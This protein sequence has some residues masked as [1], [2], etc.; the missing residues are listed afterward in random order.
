MLVAMTSNPFGVNMMNAAFS[1]EEYQKILLKNSKENEGKTQ[2]P[3]N[4]K[5][6]SKNGKEETKEPGA[7]ENVEGIAQETEEQ[8]RKNRILEKIGWIEALPHDLLENRDLIPLIGGKALEGLYGCAE[9][10]EELRKEQSKK[11]QKSLRSIE[12]RLRVSLHKNERGNNEQGLLA[13][14]SKAPAHLAQEKQLPNSEFKGFWSLQSFESI[15]TNKV[16]TTLR[17]PEEPSK[18]EPEQENGLNMLNQNRKMRETSNGFDFEQ[19][20]GREELGETMRRAQL[21]I[22]K[23]KLL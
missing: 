21:L 4:D 13:F 9:G 12:K 7:V 14:E 18:V 17:N 1:M 3:G 10:L 23:V 6:E 15:Q 5:E 2:G 19:I 16:G 11:T 22:Q 8:R 20:R